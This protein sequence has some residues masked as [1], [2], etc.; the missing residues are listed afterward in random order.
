MESSMPALCQVF[1]L[2]FTHP[3]NALANII[4]SHFDMAHLVIWLH[5]WHVGVPRPGT[6]PV[7]IS[8]P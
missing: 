3:H 2:M 4:Y 8:S 5:S 1:S 6:E 7:T